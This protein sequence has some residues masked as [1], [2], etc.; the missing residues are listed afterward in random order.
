MA[1]K[2][3]QYRYYADGPVQTQP[4]EKNQPKTISGDSGNAV[5][6]TLEHYKSGLVFGDAFPVLQLGVQ[7]LPGTKFF[8]NNA[9]EP[10]IIGSTGIYEL[11]LGGQT[12]I[13]AISFEGKSMELIRDNNNAFL[14]VDVIYDDGKE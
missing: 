7:A 4:N 10:I 3:K 5:P 2:I 6:V 14:I 12:E 9:L 11:D 1:N 13:T 8:L